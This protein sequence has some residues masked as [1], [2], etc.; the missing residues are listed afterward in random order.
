[1]RLR[2]QSEA[3]PETSQRRV[4]QPFFPRSSPPAPVAP[5]AASGRLTGA[6]ERST[7]PPDL[8]IFALGEMAGRVDRVM[9][10]RL[11]ELS[12]RGAGPLQ[13]RI[14]ETM[15]AAILDGRLSPGTAVPSSR[16]LSERLGVARNT[17]VLAYQHLIDDG[18]L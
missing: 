3:G 16:D 18:F 4:V 5:N 15:V 8:R 10:E 11:F 6:G 1:S 7:M 13:A 2:E 12:S 9:W 14:R 17:V